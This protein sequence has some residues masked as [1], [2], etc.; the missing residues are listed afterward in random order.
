MESNA[1]C[2]DVSPKHQLCQLFSTCTK[3]AR[4]HDEA[5]QSPCPQRTDAPLEKPRWE[6]HSPA[7][8][9][10]TREFHSREQ[11]E[12]A[13]PGQRTRASVWG[14]K[15][16]FVEMLAS[17]R[18]SG[19]ISRIGTGKEEKMRWGNAQLQDQPGCWQM[20]RLA[21]ERGVPRDRDGGRWVKGGRG[22]G[23]EWVGTH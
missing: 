13:S 5:D 21:G 6:M 17:S 2:P 3:P 4:T 22:K 7:L 9:T 20:V 11:K 23:E 14:E 19:S 1:E 12:W 16:S 8:I 10:G 18:L 15:T